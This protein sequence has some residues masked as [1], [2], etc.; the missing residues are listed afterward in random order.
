M[1]KALLKFVG[2]LALLVAI[3]FVALLVLVDTNQY[4]AAIEDAVAVNTGYELT[5]AG[6]LDLEL[7]PNLGLTLNDVRLKNPA[8]A[9]E[10]ASTSAVSLKV[11]ASALT[12][13][14]ILIQEFTSNDFH[15]NYTIDADGNSH[16]QIDDSATEVESTE[17]NDSD[18]GLVSATFEKLTIENASIDI[19]DQQAGSRSSLN[20]VNL[21][22]SNLNI[23]GIPFPLNL[24]FDY[25]TYSDSTGLAEP[26]PM[27][28]RSIVD[29]DLDRGIV[30]ISEFNFTL[31]P[32]FLQGQ[33]TVNDLNGTPNIAG[34]IR[35]NPFDI[36]EFIAAFSEASGET[37]AIDNTDNSLPRL[38]FALTFNGDASKI[39]VP[40]LTAKLG[41][42]QLD[43]NIDV[44]LATQFTPMNVNYNLSATTLDISPFLASSDEANSAIG[45]AQAAAGAAS[46]STDDTALPVD[47]LA[48]TNLIGSI[49]IDALRAGDYQF[50]NI[51]VYT[52][53]ENSVLDI[54][55]QPVSA[56]DGS[57]NGTIRIDGRSPEAP[58]TSQFTV[59]Q[60]DLIDLAPSISR[61][62]SVTGRLNIVS[63]LNASAA[64]TDS[65][66]NTLNGSTQFA[67][68]DNSVDIGVIKQI[69]TTISALSPSGGS[70]QE[71]PDQLKFSQLGG[72]IVLDNG[73]ADNQLINLKMDNFQ[74]DGTGGVDLDNGDFDYQLAFTLLGEP[75]LQTIPIDPLYHGVEWP[76]QCA[77]PFAAEVG[78]YCR[79]DFTRVREIF[80][81]IGANALRNEIQDTITDQV[82]EDLRDAARGLLQNILN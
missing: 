8:Y 29:A 60:L 73:I 40:T 48:S 74:L 59:R 49:S 16:W 43:G 23:E 19:Q 68:S 58:M 72:F 6:D 33:L 39:S 4:R 55:I 46:S 11:S 38:D 37:N 15:V 31:T 80:G 20:N 13:G 27:S 79:P 51:N 30:E 82:P 62:N 14:R 45:E 5:I 41:E 44:S 17:T 76:V 1:L 67:I 70:I 32:L 75:E 22:S 64:S 35:S 53:I 54:E 57:I 7:F 69:F 36:N 21:D 24:Q 81:R 2:G 77:A 61:F 42:N 18:S 9:Q 47:L 65:L 50:E 12:Q 63:E 34:E 78:Q 71:W 56:F 10:L 52:N 26:V 3:L 66:L 25:V 28:F